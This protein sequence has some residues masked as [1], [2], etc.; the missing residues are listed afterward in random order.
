MENKGTVSFIGT[1]AMA[2]AVIGGLVRSGRRCDD[3]F[4]FDICA[5]RLEDVK[6]SFGIKTCTGIEE[7]VSKD[8]VIL[9]VKPQDAPA[10]LRGIED[11]DIKL[12]I[13]IAAGLN[14]AAIERHVKGPV[15]RVMPNLPAFAGAGMSVI[16]PGRRAE[17]RHIDVCRDIFESVGTVEIIEDERHMDA[18][19]ALSGSGPA[20]LFR[21][22]KALCA[23]GKEQGLSDAA[24]CSLAFAA[25]KGAV[26]YKEESAGQ[27]DELIKKV[28]SPKGTTEAGLKVMDEMGFDCLVKKTIEAA[29]RRSKEISIELNSAL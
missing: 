18:V 1:G 27:I 19:T 8:C 23:A 6:R 7:A 26:I 3:I 12:F 2:R 29:C 21:F 20:F 22:L 28:A 5:Q 4:G 15:I 9:C 24:A 25:V 13:S 16:C 14:A 10:V 11:T 17:K